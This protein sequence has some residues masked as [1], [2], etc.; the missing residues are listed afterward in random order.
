[1]KQALLI[2]AIGGIAV[3]A[4]SAANMFLLYLVLR[5][6]KLHRVHGSMEKIG[7]LPYCVLLAID[8]EFLPKYFHFVL[9]HIQVLMYRHINS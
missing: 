9:F 6:L 2:N 5:W 1:M 8:F 3:M 4:W 7:M